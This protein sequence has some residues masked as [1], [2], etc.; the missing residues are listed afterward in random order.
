ML[1]WNDFWE[2]TRSSYVTFLMACVLEKRV[3][4]MFLILEKKSHLEQDQVNRR[5][6]PAL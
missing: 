4:L 2:I 3:P 5:V 6:G 1:F